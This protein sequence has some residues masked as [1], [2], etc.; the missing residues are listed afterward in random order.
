M[1]QLKRKSSLWIADVNL[2]GNQSGPAKTKYKKKRLLSRLVDNMSRK[3]HGGWICDENDISK[4]YCPFLSSRNGFCSILVTE[5]LGSTE[6]L[7]SRVKENTKE[8]KENEMLWGKRSK[9]WFADFTFLVVTGPIR[10]NI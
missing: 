5:Q 7:M 2:Q 6:K 1:A 4:G 9:E 8:H 10:V 3:V